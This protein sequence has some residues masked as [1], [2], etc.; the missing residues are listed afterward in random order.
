MDEAT[1]GGY[2]TEAPSP[3]QGYQSKYIVKELCQQLRQSISPEKWT[4]F[5]EQKTDRGRLELFI[6]SEEIQSCVTRH[7]QL[8]PS[9]KDKAKALVL[10]AAGNKAFGRGDNEEALHLYTQCLAWMP[11]D[12]TKGKLSLSSFLLQQQT[13]MDFIS[14]LSLFFLLSSSQ[15]HCI[16]LR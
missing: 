8:H 2:L 6:N 14:P 7:L 5:C 10:K 1:E 4:K 15:H 13:H 3:G 16:L 11:Y 9:S 12:E